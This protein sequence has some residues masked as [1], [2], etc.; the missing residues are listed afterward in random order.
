[1]SLAALLAKVLM[2]GHSLIG[3]D[4]PG[5]V[6]GGL[7]AGGAEATVEA[8]I[9]N[10]APLRWSREK[11]AEAQGVNGPERLAAGDVDVLVLTEAI[12]LANHVEWSDSAAEVA[13]WAGLA[14]A[15]NPAAQVYVYETWHDLRS[16]SG[17]AVEHDAGAGLA[18]AD[19]IAADRAVWWSL[20]GAANAARPAG[21][22]PVRLI[23]AGQALARVAAAAERGEI[24]GLTGAADLFADTIHPNGRGLYVVALTQAAVIGGLDPQAL[25]DRLGRR[26]LSREAVIPPETGA[27][28]RR[29]VA[30]ALAEWR[31]E[32]ERLLAAPASAAAPAPPP[33][34]E[35]QPEPAT[36]P[37]APA[38]PPQPDPAPAA[39]AAPAIAPSFGPDPAIA[40]LGGIANPNLGLGLSPVVD[41]SVQQPF[42]NVMKTARPWVGHLP[43]QWG[44]YEAPQLAADGHVGPDG[45]PR[46]VPE[47]VTGL[48][49]LVLTD[50]P[51]GTGGVAG[52]YV[53]TWTGQGDLRAEG[54][55]Q[56]VE[57]APG[58]IVLDY[59]PG[60]GGVILTLAA[61]DPADPPRDMV[62]V[63]ADR[64]AALAA[65]AVF[66]PD[67]LARLRG[68][69]LVRFMDWMATN[70]ATLSALADRP[71]PGDFT[72]AARGVPMEV[73]VALAN[74]L[75]ADPWFTIP[76]LAE[77]ALVAE[78]ARIAR[79]GLAPGLVAH[80]EFSNEVWNWQFAQAAWADQQARARWSDEAAWV[81]FY[82]LRAAEVA[83]I[84]AATFGAE[85]P[86]RLVRVVA[87]QTGWIG[88]EEQI[89]NAPR[90]L[91]EGRPAPALSFDAYAVTAYVDGG[92]GEEDR[93]PLV[94]DWLAQSRKMAAAQAAAAGLAGPA[95]DSFE[96]RHAWDLALSQAAAEIDTGFVTGRTEGTIENLATVV[97]PYHAAV[98]SRFGLRLVMYEG[99]SH[100][101]GQGAAREDAEITAFLHALSYSE[102]MGALYRRLLAVWG[103]LTDAPFNAFTDVD[104]PTKWGAWGALRHLGD[105]NPRWRALAGR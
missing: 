44:G 105:D 38:P 10:G 41:W 83:G 100:L 30:G 6:E 92:L 89:L 58:R 49:T 101:V 40:A 71:R 75:R 45:W 70:N 86:Q 47:G 48:S 60:P 53:L 96:Q 19:R 36:A 8:Q 57:A 7:E 32:E 12:P 15:A 95:A 93:A 43:G 50:L 4:L 78:L 11:A 69:R 20:A 64:A 27:A 84:W 76:H 37:A 73:M 81:Q 103:G 13:A 35:P 22:P 99:G 98:A 59:A 17:A 34:P 88:L 26:W 52:R 67:W 74:E 23:P 94:R 85:A 46:L 16:G 42:L 54:R 24:P 104:A 51:E 63:R 31:A 79:E 2:V 72:W 87:T 14:W 33:E 56:V 3:P 39:A 29:E 21:A 62:L 102:E 25:P 5:M 82:A 97:L 61:I 55:A 9:I 65:G 28:I 80:V 1:M 91:A 77:D 90:V 66:N 18:W 68:A